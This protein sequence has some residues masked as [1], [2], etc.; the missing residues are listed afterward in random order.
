M[1]DFPTFSDL[2]AV[3]RDEALAKN[4]KLT[5]EKANQEGT[6]V[7]AMLAASA[8]V[9]D[10][11]IGQLSRT[12]AK[13]FLDSA[14]GKDLDR[15]VFDRYGIV[16][17]SAS[18]AVGSVEFT[19]TAPSAS[20]F[21]IPV[22]TLVGTAD[23]RQ[24]VTT[25]A[26]TY[27]LGSTGPVLVAVR[28]V[29]AGLSQQAS[30]NTITSILSQIASSPADLRVTNP[31]A[32]AGADDDELDPSLR[33]RA[34]QF[35]TNARRGTLGAIQAAALGVLGVTTATAFEQTDL[36]GRPAK[37][38]QLVV[39]DTFTDQLV[40]FGTTPAYNTQ[41]QVLA[42]GVSAALEDVRAAGIQVS[43]RVAQVV[44]Q[45]ITLTLTFVAGVNYDDVALRA[46]AAVV[47]SINSLAPGQTLQRSVLVQALRSVAGLVVTGNEIYAPSGDVVPLPLQVIRT[48]MALT[49][50]VGLQPTGALQSSLNPDSA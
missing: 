23:G 17:K 42:S 11:V 20:A 44:M 22:G 32:T 24:Y 34:R 7:N 15:L 28:S 46:R 48:S 1:A 47:F 30:T 50:P 27:A 19:T 9:G 38:V 5:L 43:T 6:D 40:A 8:A 41:S 18:P 37:G 33:N 26:G 39:A 31:L 12:E 29:L 10:E 21:A 14:E 35:F 13:T 25:T 45:G 16:R 36:L 49:V 4:S 2:F 3:S